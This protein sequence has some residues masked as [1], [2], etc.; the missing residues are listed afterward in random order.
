MNFKG[1]VVSIGNVQTGTSKA[2]KDWKKQDVV[3]EQE[4]TQYPDSLSVTFFNKEINF[5][6]GDLVTITFNIKATEYNGRYFNN[7]SAFNWEVIGDSQKKNQ[8]QQT[9]TNDMPSAPIAGQSGNNEQPETI[10][11]DEGDNLPF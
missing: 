9:T 7:L 5:S 3:L 4:A 10:G 8:S 2:G 6:V 11:S 1:R